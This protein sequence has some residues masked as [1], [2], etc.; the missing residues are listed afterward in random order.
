MQSGGQF[1]PVTLTEAS[2]AEIRQRLA[3][4]ERALLSALRGVIDD[5]HAAEARQA[6][7]RLAGSL[8]LLGM[9]RAGD[10]AGEMERLLQGG[11]SPGSRAPVVLADLRSEVERGLLAQSVAKPDEP[12][13]ATWPS[14]GPAARILVAEDDDIMARMIEAA[15]SRQGY[16]VTRTVNGAEAVSLAA[17][18]PFDL[19]LLDLQMP[20]MTGAEACLA[21]RKHA[22]LADVPIVLLTAQSNHQQVRERSLPGMT[23]YLIKPF[24]LADLRRQVQ[25]WLSMDAGRAEQR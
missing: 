13:V 6:A 10:L 22:H 5:I 24:G 11:D 20:V 4:I 15:L 14:A 7:H 1:D 8:D 23:D 2:R 21:L 16:E 12:A 17:G 25:R 19:I 3:T 18:R 9:T